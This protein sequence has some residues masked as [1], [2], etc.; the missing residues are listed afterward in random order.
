M[1]KEEKKMGKI[2]PKEQPLVNDVC[3]RNKKKSKKNKRPWQE[4]HYTC[5]FCDTYLGKIDPSK[6]IYY[7]VTAKGSGFSRMVDNISTTCVKCGAF[8]IKDACPSCHR[9]TWFKPDDST[10]TLGEYKHSK[11]YL[12]C[13]FV[14][15]LKEK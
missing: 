2:K 13:G 7:F 12:G 9:D 3:N 11:R 15:R 8:E 4:T 10:C 14:G 5:P 6:E 1:S